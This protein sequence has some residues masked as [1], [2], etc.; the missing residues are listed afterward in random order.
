MTL[1]ETVEALLKDLT[2]EN[3][4]QLLPILADALADAGFDRQESALRWA[5]AMGKRPLLKE[6]IIDRER[7]GLVDSYGIVY[8]RPDCW[9]KE[10]NK[11]SVLPY[12]YV[13]ELTHNQSSGTLLDG[14]YY[15]NV[16]AAWRSFLAGADEHLELLLKEV[17]S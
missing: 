1:T 17:K 12:K 8:W 9:N 13:R 6:E 11:W 10:E 14:R 4:H 16:E 7:S 15:D 3:Q 5:L 2:A